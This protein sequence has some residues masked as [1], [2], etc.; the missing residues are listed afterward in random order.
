Y[1]TKRSLN[2]PTSLSFTSSEF[3]KLGRR[4]RLTE[5]L[6]MDFIARNTTIPI[7]RVLDVYSMDGKVHLVQ[8]CIRG[9]VLEDVWRHLSRAQQQSSM[10]QL[11]DCLVQLHNLEPPNYS[12]R[13]QAA[14][15]FPDAYPLV[16]DT[17]SKLQ[18]RR[19]KTVFAH[20]DLGP[21]NIIWRKDTERIVIIDWETAGWFPA[22][23]DYTRARAAR[24][25]TPW[26]DMFRETVGHVYD[27]ELEFDIQA[28]KYFDRI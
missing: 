13:V 9:P 1:T 12:E 26:W 15:G 21:H 27:N 19:Y 5:A 28:G 16:Q 7:P 25:G 18:S 11:R 23:W 22:Y 4:V 6:T 2:F 14:D 17:L 20:G 24:G 8:E 10:A 3:T